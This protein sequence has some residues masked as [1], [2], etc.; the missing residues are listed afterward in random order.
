MNVF[1]SETNYMNNNWMFLYTL[2]SFHHYLTWNSVVVLLVSLL[3]D[4]L[5]LAYQQAQSHLTVPMPSWLP[6]RR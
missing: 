5:S 2:F 4:Q 3:H 1:F 6:Q